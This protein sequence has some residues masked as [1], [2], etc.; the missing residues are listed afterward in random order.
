[1]SLL[2]LQQTLASTA[3][4]IELGGLAHSRLFPQP[5]EK[6]SPLAN[7]LVQVAAVV[8]ASDSRP[9]YVPVY[10][11]AAVIAILILL[12]VLAQRLTKLQRL[13]NESSQANVPNQSTQRSGREST[14]RDPF[15][16]RSWYASSDSSVGVDSIDG[17][18]TAAGSTVCAEADIK[19]PLP[20][21]RASLSSRVL[22]LLCLSNSDGSRSS[23]AQTFCS[24]CLNNRR[25]EK[26]AQPFNC[27][28]RFHTACLRSY[29]SKSNADYCPLCARSG[30]PRCS[31]IPTES[32]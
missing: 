31:G 3:K 32:V 9:T 5:R 6:M 30:S 17:G 24:I 15:D 27:G 14:R 25:G 1:M 26:W 12:L 22:S 10:A 8:R 20:M 7:S 23:S 28:H 18:S 2:F 4:S 21:P 29:I 13:R 11:L 16:M 19:F